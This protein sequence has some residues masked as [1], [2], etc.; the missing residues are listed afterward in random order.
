MRIL[1]IGEYSRLHNSLK[2]GLVSLGHDVTIAGSGD[3]FKQFPVDFFVA[4]KII[5]NNKIAF[6][7]NRVA[8]KLLNFDFQKL[9]RAVRFLC[10]LPK[11]KNYDV[12]QIINSDAIE[13]FPWVS[14]QLYKKLMA[15]NKR[16]FLLIC[17]DETPIIEQ[18]LKNEVTYS[19]LTPLIENPKLQKNFSYSLKYVAPRYRKLYEFIKN[20][21]DAILVS[22]LDYK[23]PMESY[24]TKVHFVANPINVDKIKYVTPLISDKIVIFHGKN[25]H[26]FLKK[27]SSFFE[28]ALSIIKQKYPNKVAIIITD[29]LPYIEYQKY[30]DQAHIV[31]DQVYSWDQGYNALEAMAKGKVVFSGAEK[32]FEAHYQLN[33]IVAINALPDVAYL[34]NELSILIENPKLILTISEN[35]RQFIVQK[36][37][38]INQSQEYL[39][40]W[41]NFNLTTNL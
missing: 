32:E 39:N 26:S 1:L 4:S 28:A 41:E 14:I 34:V 31:L 30:I 12:V 16:F 35:A 6:F 36:H 20:N 29:S 9:E 38:Y 3:D 13:T 27:G 8:I 10:F 33:K 40:V 21:C 15:Q 24:K 5:S 22:D 18:L 17:G 11:M 23:I 2:E 19:V 7:L 37:H 25:K